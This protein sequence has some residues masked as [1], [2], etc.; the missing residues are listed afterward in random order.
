V[1]ERARRAEITV[2]Q[3]LTRYP[4][5]LGV[6]LAAAALLTA[7]FTVARPQ[8]G[9]KFSGEMINLA[10]QDYVSPTA[11]R[12]AF[13]AEGVSLRYSYAFANG[14]VLSDLPPARQGRG[15]PVLVTVG[16]RTGRVSYGPKITP[17]DQRFENVLVTYSGADEVVTDRL[18]AAVAALKR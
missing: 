6:T 10:E 11:A 2:V 8:S 4:V 12:A 9:G 7:L 3:L 16:G 1:A 14:V 17:Y 13:K 18:D 15:T 5:V